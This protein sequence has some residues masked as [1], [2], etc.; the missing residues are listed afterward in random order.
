MAKPI[1]LEKAYEQAVQARDVPKV[2][3][4]INGF[5]PGS[6]P[7]YAADALHFVCY[8]GSLDDIKT[9]IEKYKYPTDTQHRSWIYQ[10]ALLHVVC[11]RYCDTK[12]EV[13]SI[14]EYLI[15]EVG[16]ST[17]VI[18]E[19]GDGLPLHVA[20]ARRSLDRVKMVS[21]GCDVNRQDE[22]GN[23]PLHVACQ[24]LN[25]NSESVTFLVEEKKCDVNVANN[26]GELPLHLACKHQ[27]NKTIVRLV[28]VGCDV[29]RQ[30]E[31]GNTP[32]HMACQ[33]GSTDMVRYL[34]EEKKCGFNVANNKGELPLHLACKR[35][36]GKEIVQLVSVGCDVNRQDE[37]GNTPL[38]MA[39]QNGSTDMV[40]YLVEEKKCGFNVANNKGELPLHLACKREYGKEIVQLVSVGCDVNRQDEAGNTPLHM[41]CQNGSTD[42]VRYLVEEK[43]CGFNVANNKGEL[44]LHLAC[45][46]CKRKYGKE[47]VQLV[48]VG[49]DVNRQDSAGNTPLHIAC[50][51]RSSNIVRFLVEE[52]GCNIFLETETGKSPLDLLCDIK[53]EMGPELVLTSIVSKYRL[54]HD[55]DYIECGL[56]LFKAQYST[57]N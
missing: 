24:N 43:K 52:K 12:K 55:V 45:K 35:E 51:R 2:L 44:P 7:T 47:I 57:H 28:S 6:I 22:A 42:M 32:L 23:T 17:D 9:L 34:V 49:C 15:N 13:S 48:S 33:N 30:D 41:A 18:S 10:G 40:R 29:N 39:C 4:I 54:Q 14:L 16:L 19:Y 53:T 20:C 3:R 1:E 31:A 38:H 46:P 25:L 27:Y 37:A 26:K 8:Y 21:V 56:I 11:N 5:E 36:Y 50:I